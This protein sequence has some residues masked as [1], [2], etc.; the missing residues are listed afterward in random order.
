[1]KGQCPVANA[2]SVKSCASE[3]PS[4]Q[5]AQQSP[6]DLFAD[7]KTSPLQGFAQFAIPVEQKPQQD[8]LGGRQEIRVIP[9]G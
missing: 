1:M 9:L 5:L 8:R 3:R 6:R 2:L 4:A 7:G